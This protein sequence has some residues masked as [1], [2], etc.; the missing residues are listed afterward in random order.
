LFGFRIFKSALGIKP[1]ASYENEGKSPDVTQNQ[2]YFDALTML[3]E[4]SAFGTDSRK[5]LKKTFFPSKK[6]QEPVFR[7]EFDILLP[8]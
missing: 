3:D 4:V 5:Y 1:T 6:S 7:S 8:R 2:F